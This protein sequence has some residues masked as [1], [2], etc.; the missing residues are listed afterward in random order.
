MHVGAPIKGDR[1]RMAM[2]RPTRLLSSLG[3]IVGTVVFFG[4]LASAAA[5]ETGFQ[6]SAAGAQ[7]PADP[8]VNGF[9]L[10]LFYGKNES[11]RGFD[12]GIA[13]LSES[14]NSAGVSMNWGIGKVTGRS[15]GLAAS[16]VNLHT[17]QDS[18]VNAAFINNVKTM[19]SGVNIGFVNVTDE[20]SYL[21]ISGM[22]IS[23]QSNIQIGFI[24]VTSR[25]DGIQIGF[26][27]FAENGL[28]PMLPI[29]NMPRK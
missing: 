26:L 6:F 28:F 2:T 8:N 14:V 4:L 19:K 9:R 25:I 1:R 23:K 29:F 22:G 12:L 3:T 5:A 11:V 7:S 10:V 21:D 27:N 15:S 13:S 16:F 20:Y 24:N 17:S 18:G